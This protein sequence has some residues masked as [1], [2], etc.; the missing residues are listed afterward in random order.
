VARILCD[1]LGSSRVEWMG[2]FVGGEC[3]RQSRLGFHIDMGMTLVSPGIAVVAR[4]DPSALSLEAHLRLL[5]DEAEH[6]LDVL[7]RRELAGQGWPEGLDLP[8]EA[9]DREAFLESRL[10]A[11]VA[12]LAHAAAEFDA[13]ASRLELVGYRVHRL[14]ADPRRVRRFQS[15]T[16]AIVSRDRMIMPIFPT[17]S[18]VHGWLVHGQGGRDRVEV[19]LGLRDSEFDLEGDNLAALELF[20]SL[21]PDVRVVRDYF[22]LASGNV[23]CVIG[24][25]T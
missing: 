4:C 6:T 15:H 1:A 13:M 3:S 18:H 20:R 25:I 2:S 9:T 19:D 21:H 16:N 12:D 14:H 24:R 17:R 22:Y 11:E 8:R 7:A 10:E 23:H 5:R